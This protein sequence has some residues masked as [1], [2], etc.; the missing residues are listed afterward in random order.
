M[1]VLNFRKFSTLL[2]STNIIFLLLMVFII[3]A[4]VFEIDQTVRGQGKLIPADRTQI[5]QVADGGVLS[6]IFVQEGDIVES[7]QPLAELEKDRASASF[8]ESRAKLASL[9]IALIRAQAEANQTAPVY[10]KDYADFSQF[11]A[12]QMAFYNQRKRSLAQDIEN[13][14]ESLQSAQQELELNKKLFLTGDTS[15][16]EVMRAQRQVTDMQ[17]RINSTRNK[18]L[19]DAR[20]EA[21]KIAE[22][23]S[24]NFYRLEERQSVLDHT[25]ITAPVSGIVKYQRITTI[26]GVLRQG[27]ELMQIS[28]TDAEPVFE[29]NIN[30]TDIGQLKKGLPVTIRLDA[31]D[32]SIY[33]VLHG[34]LSYISSDTL[35]EQGPNGQAST[36]YRAHVR[37]HAD[38]PKAAHSKLNSTMLKPGMTATIDVKAGTRSVLKY[39]IKPIYKAFG[40]ALTER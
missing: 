34:T 30:P 19:Q 23:L 15:Q 3:W 18:Y 24:T 38:A 39:L 40:G 32:Y 21:A 4:A 9:E 25:T 5:I 28:P 13:L 35:T 22:E 37:L 14:S 27:D 20:A 12:L 11:Q 1:K 10:G 36:F 29:I 2:T 26:G 33:G 17:G 16:L 6:R 31:F 7:G 8:T